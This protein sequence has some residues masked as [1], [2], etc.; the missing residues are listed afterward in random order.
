MIGMINIPN[1]SP[2]EFYAAPHHYRHLFEDDGPSSSHKSH[3]DAD[4][5]SY[6]SGTSSKSSFLSLFSRRKNRQQVTYLDDGRKVFDG[7]VV[8]SPTAPKLWEQLIVR[9]FVHKLEDEIQSPVAQLDTIQEVFPQLSQKQKALSTST[10]SLV[11]QDRIKSNC[12]KCCPKKK[13]LR[14]CSLLSKSSC[15][16]QNVGNSSENHKKC[17]LAPS[18][19]L[20]R[21]RS[22][23]NSENS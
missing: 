19:K 17:S 8:D 7:Q 12:E 14:Q 6:A 23:R 16:L 22:P 13:N 3:K 18:A 4:A 10:Y 2:A 1:D 9:T 11:S 20:L 21:R 5:V 15:K